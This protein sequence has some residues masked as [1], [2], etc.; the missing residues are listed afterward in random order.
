MDNNRKKNAQTATIT[1]SPRGRVGE[2]L[3]GFGF[4]AYANSRVEKLRDEGRY[5]AA[6]KLKMYLRRFIAYL[7]KNEV[8]F[9][10]FDALLMRNYHT[11]LKNQELGRNTI[12]LYI[13]N[14]KR[15]YKLAVNDGLAADVNP[16]EGL[17]VSYHVKK[18]RNG[19]TLDEV[20]L[21][22]NLD[23][24]REPRQV[25]FAR[26]IFL[27]TV[28]TRGMKSD[29]IFRLTKENVKDGQLTYRQH[30]TGKEI[31]MPWEPLMQEIADRYKRKGTALLFPV[32]TA[33]SPREQ[34]KQYDGILHR[35][36]YSLKK[37]G[38]MIGLGYPLN[39][40]V[41][42]HSWE[43]MTKSVSISDLL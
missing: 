31:S 12:S 16:F 38:E 3:G 11:W 21:L 32:I 2:G 18:Y 41:A 36:N 34:W 42:R 14:L 5:D 30:L 17:D 39:L 10:D 19:L 25:V 24:S 23:L 4:I 37:L 29:D 20:K 40:T 6:Y 15:V 27:F 13:R 35:I 43:S 9:K 26:D 33:K 7:G 1:L 8:P 22:R 28:Y